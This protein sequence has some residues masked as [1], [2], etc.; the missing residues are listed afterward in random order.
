MDRD[1]PIGVF[2]S[3]V[4]GLS[5]LRA[6]RTELPQEDFVY[7]SDAGHAPYGEKGEAFVTDRS[8]AIAVDLL[9]QH[10]IKALVIACNTA[11]AAAVH[12]LRAKHTQLPV[13]GVEPALKP[14]AALTKTGHVAVLATRGTLASAKFQALQRSLQGQAEFVLVPCDGLAAAI[15][16]DDREQIRE[17]CRRY[18][19]DVCCFGTGPGDIDTLV[20]GCT[21]YP[22]AEEVFRELVGPEVRLVETGEPVARQTRR[23]LEQKGLLNPAGQ[24]RVEWQTTGS[25]D[26]LRSAAARWLAL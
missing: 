12:L 1:R 25:P 3:G 7:F 5:I 6:L 19:R 16:A 13:V 26:A 8:L 24:G 11:T 9:E 15:E 17:L 21:H 20:L 4:G 23:L 22:F 14:A 10:R 18:T 2:D